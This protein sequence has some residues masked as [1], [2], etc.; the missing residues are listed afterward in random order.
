VHVRD[1]IRNRSCHSLQ[2]LTPLKS[3]LVE[4]VL[5]LAFT[6]VIREH[7]VT[8]GIETDAL[9]EA[10][11]DDPIGVN[12]LA[13]DDKGTTTTWLTGPEGKLLIRPRIEVQGA[14]IGH[15]AVDSGS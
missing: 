12:V 15:L 7:L 4:G 2:E 3:R 11:R 9:Q 5:T 6:T 8:Q 14:D 10:G 13:A 1:W